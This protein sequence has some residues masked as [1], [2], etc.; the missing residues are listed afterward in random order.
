MKGLNDVK[1][2]L[3]ASENACARLYNCR[4]VSERKAGDSTM[5]ATQY[6]WEHPFSNRKAVANRCLAEDREYEDCALNRK[7]TDIL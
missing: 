4:G 2:T 1:E 7:E 5:I 6:G 3:R